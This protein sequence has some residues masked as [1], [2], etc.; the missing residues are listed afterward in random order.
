MT[1]SNQDVFHILQQKS[2]H[3][4]KLMNTGLKDHGIYMSQ[5]SILFCIDKF[6]AMTQK[7]ICSYL[8]VEAPTITRTLERMEKSGLITRK[9]GRDKR[10]RIIDLT[11]DARERFADIKASVET[12]E[13]EL[14]RTFTETEKKQLYDLLR[15]IEPL[16]E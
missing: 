16:G 3:L 13:Q 1:L 10:E 8:H 12:K 7:E 11:E 6:G 14:L 4:T 9:Q 2:R 5:W 15:K